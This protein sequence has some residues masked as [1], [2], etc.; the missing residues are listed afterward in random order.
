MR[1]TTTLLD[2]NLLVALFD[3]VHTHHE[4]AHSWFSN[5]NEKA[6]ATCPITE[7]GLLRIITN[8]A[9]P[10]RRTTLRDALAR[11][12]QFRQSKHHHFWADEVTLCDE[13]VDPKHIQGYRQLTDVYLLALA[14][15]KGG[16]LA[17]FDRGLSVSA[18]V[19]AS[20]KSVV[21]VV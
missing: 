15:A 10:G 1:A 21:Q 2:V 12:T 9:Y 5:N 7:N 18:V 4:V 14:V 16:R 19:G 8:P 13:V 3:G 20:A 11:L 17:T 6:W